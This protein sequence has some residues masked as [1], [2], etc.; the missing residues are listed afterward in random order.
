[1]APRKKTLREP[2]VG[3][4]E[5]K[6]QRFRAVWRLHGEK[7][8]KT[9]DTRDEACDFLDEMAIGVRRGGHVTDASRPRTPF[10]DRAED[11]YAGRPTSR[12][13]SSART[14]E[15]SAL[16]RHLLPAFGEMA[17][18]D[19]T[20]R[21][22]QAWINKVREDPAQDCDVCEDLQYREQDDNARCDKHAKTRPLA[23]AT[24]HNYY[25]ILSQIIRDAY[26]DGYGH[27]GALCPI[28]KGLHS[29][30]SLSG[31]GRMT[32]LSG[33]ELDHLLEVA[34]EIALKD[35]AIVHLA[36]HTGMRQGELFGLQREQ[37][38]SLGAFLWVDRAAKKSATG[39]PFVGTTKTN[40]GRRIDLTPCCVEVL[41]LHLTGHEERLIFPST[42]GG[43]PHNAG[44]KAGDIGVPKHTI[45]P[46]SEPT[47]YAQTPPRTTPQSSLTR[48]MSGV[49][50]PLRPLTSS[51][52]RT[53]PRGPCRRRVRA[54]SS[55]AHRRLTAPRQRVPR[56]NPYRP[57]PGN[58]DRVMLRKLLPTALLGVAGTV[59]VGLI[60]MQAPGVLANTG[61]EF[62][63]R[64]DDTT[65]LVLVDDDDDADSN[66]D[67][68]SRFTG[69]SRATGDHT[70]SN[71][72]RVSRDRDLSRS[73]KTRD[74]TDDGVGP[75]K[76]D[77]SGGRTNDHTRND[78]RW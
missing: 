68:R 14:R 1:M 55:R 72:T 47:F 26:L 70:R 57:R 49:R 6:R 66:D 58:E 25:G 44:D 52:H 23:P 69:F 13:H 16:K 22:I 74:W 28:G 9:F 5:A 59:T 45:Q 15:R 76:R 77:W 65:E 10:R 18:G 73:D 53:R 56:Q 34:G 40:N 42:R 62:T 12:E 3:S 21:D 36:A 20:R 7:Q 8:Y 31:G 63:K 32:C 50:S 41:N 75:K 17:I 30:P 71:F 35:Y 4:V 39:T 24:V 27:H 43:R 61:D 48:K 37:Y 19:I 78:S 29:L 33:N 51:S 11:W 46:H 60:A 64:E 2:E 54:V 38:N 67:T